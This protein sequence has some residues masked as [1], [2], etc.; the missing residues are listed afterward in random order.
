MCTYIVSST[1]NNYTQSPFYVTLLHRVSSYPH[2][3]QRTKSGRVFYNRSSDY[4]M[5]WY[6]IDELKTRLKTPILYPNSRKIVKKTN[7]K[8]LH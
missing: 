3:K 4:F 7:C 6:Q 2:K 8:K 5:L 1:N